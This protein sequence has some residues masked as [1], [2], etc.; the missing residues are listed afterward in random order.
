MTCL[1]CSKKLGFFSRYKDTPFCSEEHL[2]AHQ[3]ELERAL[4][5]RLGS[6]AKPTPKLLP[7][8]FPA[9]PSS[10]RSPRNSDSQTRLETTPSLPHPGPEAP[11]PPIAAASRLPAPAPPTAKPAPA[12]SEPPFS[13][14][15]L[16]ELP[17]AAAALRP[18]QPHAPASAFS[19]LLTAACYTPRTSSPKLDFNL[20]CQAAPVAIESPFDPLSGDNSI[21]LEPY[22]NEEH[23]NFN[24]KLHLKNYSHPAPLSIEFFLEEAIPLDYEPA[25]S[26]L[27]HHALGE[28]SAIPPRPRLRYPYAASELTSA[29]NVLSLGSASVDV[30]FSSILSAAPPNPVSPLDPSPGPDTTADGAG[31]KEASLPVPLAGPLFSPAQVNL[32]SLSSSRAIDLRPKSCSGAFR[33]T[34]LQP[35]PALNPLPGP[36]YLPA[37]SFP[38]A[39]QLG[40]KLPPRP[41]SM[42]S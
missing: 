22:L 16:V 21:Q 37:L 17:R 3:E 28:R 31:R 4:M 19:I 30:T 6:K 2:R 42:V 23:N 27:P 8:L 24:L 1:H 25:I 40:P 39:Y 29:A 5:E 32:D 35:A 20:A 18:N 7:D 14:D 34:A 15:Y 9:Q 38:S 12:P 10:A 36:S 26:L 41:E 13:E 11:L 33:W